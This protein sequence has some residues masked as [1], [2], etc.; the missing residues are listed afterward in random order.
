MDR[1]TLLRAATA[2]LF[3]GGTVARG[4]GEAAAVSFY[5]PF[6]GYQITGTWQEHIDRGSLGGIDYGVSVGT[7]LPAA[8]GGTV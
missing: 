4:A 1:R 6:S 5:N 8:G 7:E 3:V 2:G